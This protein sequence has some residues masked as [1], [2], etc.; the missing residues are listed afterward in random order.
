MGGWLGS[1]RGPH[2]HPHPLRHEEP[3]KEA[4]NFV[5]NCENMNDFSAE[6]IKDLVVTQGKTHSEV[7]LLLEEAFPDKRG[8]S[9]RS[10]RRFCFENGIHLLNRLSNDELEECTKDVVARV[11]ILL[12]TPVYVFL[13][14]CA[15]CLLYVTLFLSSLL[16][17]FI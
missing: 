16:Y 12:I 14:P 3:G 10:V 13:Y 1:D 9:S 17:I 15:V 8:L 2:P 5:V 11:C 7:S 6:Y 4:G